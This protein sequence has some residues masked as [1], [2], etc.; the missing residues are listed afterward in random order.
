MRSDADGTLWVGSGDGASWGYADPLALRTYDEQSMAGK[1]M[2]IDREGRGL[3]GHPFCPSN[4][5]LDAV[6]TKIHA[7]GFRN[8]FKFTLRP[9]GRGL[10]VGDVGWNQREE[11]DLVS[12]GGTGYG[13]P[14]YEGTQRTP[15][16]RD[17]PECQAEYA[18]EG[19]TEAHRPPAY[20]YLHSIGSTVIMGPTYSASHYPSSYNG[21]IFYGDFSARTIR[22]VVV[23]GQDQVTD[24]KDFA[25]N[26][27]SLVGLEQAPNGNLVALDIGTFSNDGAIREIV[28]QN[29][30]PTAVAS[31]TPTSGP[32]P[33]TVDFTGSSS[34]DPD[35]EGLTYDWDFGDGSAHS[36]AV[37]PRHVYTSAGVYTARLTVSDGQGN[38]DSATVTIRPGNDAPTANITAPADGSLY[39]GGNTITLSGTGTDAQ[40]G[41]LAASALDWQVL[42]HHGN[43]IHPLHQASGTAQ[44]SFTAAIDHDA[45]SYYEVTLTARDSTGLT[46]TRS[47]SL[48]P[49]TTTAKITSSPTGAPVTYGG[50]DFTTP[51]DQPTA[52]GFRTSL[53]ADP[54][55]VRDGRTFYFHRWSD[56][57]PRVRTGFTVPPSG[58]DL[59]A[60]YRE[61]K[62][63]ARTATASSVQFPGVEAGQAIDGDPD[64]RW[65]SAFA[66]NQWWQ[67]DLGSNRKVDNVR[68]D[69]T[70][71]YPR[72]YLIQTSADGNTW[73]TAATQNTTVGPIR[74]RP[75]G[76]RDG[77]R[78]THR[79]LRARPNPHA[80]NVLGRLLRGCPRPR[81]RGR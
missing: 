51:V 47:I 48:R 21:N 2:H 40:D 80:R 79:A 6:C 15:G 20:E 43:H 65:G 42:L 35:D 18:K 5:N 76:G 73:S 10:A 67:V 37:N 4:G 3:P 14:C 34:S 57:G 60:F 27:D 45:D 52:V 19:T 28:Y 8:P 53:T 41:N 77:L 7:K 24:T 68:I 56:D 16:Y 49:E 11:I 66:D 63:F 62:A 36:A 39:R 61:D 17:F 9:Q 12:S 29:S 30:E 33:L 74:R 70:A 50:R 59:R 38:S 46:G 25:T 31:A 71:A 69:W 1:I 22:T 26:W 55:F 32:T 75:R 81:P 78:H 58:F 54:S 23:N 64:T 13:W 72:S 44:T